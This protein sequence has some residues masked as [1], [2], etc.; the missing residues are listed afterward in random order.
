M[1]F[2][3][4]EA[5]IR[6]DGTAELP[7]EEIDFNGRIGRVTEDEI[8]AASLYWRFGEKWGLQTQYYFE[9][10]NDVSAVLQEDIEWEDY[11][12]R[13]GSEAS[14]GLDVTIFRIFFGREF[15]QGT[16]HL[17]GV[18]AGVHWMEIGAFAEG[19]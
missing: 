3:S 2:P 4:S 10:R 8:G 12:I 9:S 6:I 18:G 1:F 13:E 17:F 19:E 11:V 16:N 14:V 15:N 5:K 7:D